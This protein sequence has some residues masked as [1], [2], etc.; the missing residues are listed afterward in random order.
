MEESS[1]VSASPVRQL[2]EWNSGQKENLHSYN[3]FIPT[4]VCI[5][6]KAK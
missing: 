4:V 6:K 1:L 2:L 3:S 5:L